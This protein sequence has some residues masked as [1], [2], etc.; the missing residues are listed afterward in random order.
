NLSKYETPG[1]SYSRGL[2]CLPSLFTKIGQKNFIPCN[3][4]DNLS[5]AAT[6]MFHEIVFNYPLKA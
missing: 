5:P 3:P 1:D 6:K 4:P 2:F